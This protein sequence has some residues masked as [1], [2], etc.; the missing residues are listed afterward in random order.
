MFQRLTRDTL[1]ALLFLAMAGVCLGQDQAPKSQNGDKQKPSQ[2]ELEKQFSERM[3]HSVMVGRFTVEGKDNVPKPERY[4]IESVTKTKDDYWTFL[5][6]IKYGKVD[7]KVPI[8]VKILWA[9]DTPV[10]SLTDLTIPGMGTFTARVLFYEDRYAGT[11]QHGEVGGNLFGR[12]EKA[13][14]EDSKME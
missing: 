2:E 14:S 12:I 10:V 5:A 7:A 8:T 4:E 9:G 11:W 1:A 13:K 3:A 6:R